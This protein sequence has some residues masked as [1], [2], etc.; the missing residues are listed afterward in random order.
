MIGDTQ[1]RIYGNGMDVT[2]PIN[3]GL[4]GER[5]TSKGK[6]LLFQRTD[7]I[8]SISTFKFVSELFFKHMSDDI[9]YYGFNI[10]SDVG[11]SASFNG[12]Q[13]TKVDAGY[14]LVMKAGITYT[15]AVKLPLSFTNNNVTAI[16]DKL[17][18]SSDNVG[19]LVADTIIK[20]KDLVTATISGNVEQNINMYPGTVE[21]SLYNPTEITVVI[22]KFNVHFRDVNE[23]TGLPTKTFDFFDNGIIKFSTSNANKLL[24]AV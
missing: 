23:A 21:L 15:I 16:T 9:E 4:I 10:G 2:I 14:Q 22:E 12:T 24:E 7:Y 17:V 20:N 13:F 18:S 11:L 3:G 5:L 8:E 1:V 19:A 6:F